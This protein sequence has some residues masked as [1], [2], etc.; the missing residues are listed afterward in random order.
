MSDN[1][2]NDK[3]RAIQPLHKSPKLAQKAVLKKERIYAEQ[4]QMDMKNHALSNNQRGSFLQSIF[5]KS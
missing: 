3:V 2:I 1:D 4:K 5:E